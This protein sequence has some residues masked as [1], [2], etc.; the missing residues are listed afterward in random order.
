MK[1]FACA[2]LVMLLCLVA[3]PVF[4]VEYI[5]FTHE[6]STYNIPASIVAQDYALKKTN[7][8]FPESICDTGSPAFKLEC[9]ERRDSLILDLFQQVLQSETKLVEHLKTIPWTKLRQYSIPKDWI[10]P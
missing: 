1:R 8:Q 3:V 4:A 6:D 2:A 10:L 5:P 9:Q 7:E